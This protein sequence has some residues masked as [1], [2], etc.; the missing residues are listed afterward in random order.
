MLIYDKT[1]IV[2]VPILWLND[3]VKI[4]ASIVP[5]LGKPLKIKKGFMNFKKVW[6]PIVW[7]PVK[8]FSHLFIEHSAVMLE[9]KCDPHR[10]LVYAHE[11]AAVMWEAQY[12]QLCK[13]TRC[14]QDAH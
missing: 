9:L 14:K 12:L 1:A 5:W 10:M 11:S 4:L 13:D 7:T 2:F 8:D 3:C 6:G